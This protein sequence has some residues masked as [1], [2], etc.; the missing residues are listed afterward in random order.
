MLLYSGTIQA[1]RNS[2]TVQVYI[3][4]FSEQNG[5]TDKLWAINLDHQKTYDDLPLME[6]ISLS[7]V[8]QGISLAISGQ[9]TTAGI[10]STFAGYVYKAQYG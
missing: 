2:S 4:Q 10:A 7:F 9:E 6:K 1:A 5:N 3:V 8:N